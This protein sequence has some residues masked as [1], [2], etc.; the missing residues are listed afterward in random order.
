MNNN[1][2]LVAALG[3]QRRG[4][5]VIPLRPQNK[6]PAIRWQGY[7][8]RRADSTQICQWL[9][10]RPNANIAIVTGEISGF[11]VLDIDP[12]HGGDESLRELEKIHG[13]LRRTVEATS[14]GGGRHI[15]FAHPGGMISNKVAIWPGIDLRGD[16]GY[17]VAPPSLHPWGKQYTWVANRD[18]EHVHLAP[19]PAWLLEAITEQSVKRHHFVNYWHDLARENVKEG[20]RNNT[21]ASLSGHLLWHG[22]DEDVVMELLLA[23]N[24]LRCRPPLSDDEVV[25]TVGSISRTQRRHAR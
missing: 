19:M 6:R 8:C 4:W 14:G 9:R 13:P 12:K 10:H 3:Y 7:Q 1:A 16:G 25:R 5:S 24:R 18:P 22:V 11:L 15:Y 17:I 20:E 2:V 21:I 23:W